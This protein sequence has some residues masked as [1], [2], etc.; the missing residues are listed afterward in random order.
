ML[1]PNKLDALNGL[2]K[3]YAVNVRDTA[4]AAII[5]PGL[6]DHEEARPP[7]LP[8][9][10]AQAHLRRRIQA[11]EWAT[12][13]ML[14]TVQALAAEYE[15]SGATVLKVLRKLAGEGLVN[16]IPSWGTFRQ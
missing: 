10:R 2:V 9:A 4:N 1:L 8:S 11:G 7:M 3:P 6:G 14:P 12:G 16:V 13:D 15:T 5:P